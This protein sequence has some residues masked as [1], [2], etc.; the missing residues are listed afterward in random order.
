MYL[1][2]DGGSTI[3]STD[4]LDKEVRPPTGLSQEIKDEVEELQQ[5]L[6]DDGLKFDV[7]LTNPP[8]SMSYKKENKDE[9]RV[10]DQYQIAITKTGAISAQEKSNVLFLERYC[11]LLK[12]GGELLTV[13][14]NTVLN[15]TDSQRYRDYILENFIVLQVVA[16]PFNTFFKAQANVQ[17]SIIH[18]KKRQEGD[19]QGNVFMAILNN[20]GHDDHQRYTPNRDN[21]PRLME[22]YARWREGEEIEHVFEPNAV[23]GENLG[24]PFQTF[25]V[26]ADQL[27]STRLDAFYYAPDLCL[28]REAMV[29][30]AEE[31]HINILDGKS[32][33]IVEIIKGAEI[34]K[35]EGKVFRYFEIGDVTKE[36]AIVN[37]R[38][39]IFENLPTRGRLRVQTNDV[40]FAKNNSSRGTAVIIPPDFD[41]QLVTTGFIAIRP[42]DYE[43]ALLL[44]CIFT[45]EAFRKQVYYLAITASQPEVRED[46]F[47]EKF[48]LPV[49]K[50]KI[51]RQ[52][53][54]ERARKVHKSQQATLKA[55]EDTR[56]M[57]KNVFEGA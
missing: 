34:S 41:G 6:I 39:D 28:T 55:V 26:P 16:L 56:R 18:I 51:Q 15:G 43:E 10:L 22:V 52:E 47:Q 2:G 9:K 46:I 21:V 44:W 54:I 3:F 24:C 32:F 19:V 11:D 57:S 25:V 23:E 42:R 7:V 37:Y 49:P 13:I 40:L 50:S 4:T 45:S 20:V 48:M 27:E 17:T 30:R 12:D 14:D 8:F 29:K 35:C 53:L 38:E 5:H 1:H 31:G 33:K 36:G